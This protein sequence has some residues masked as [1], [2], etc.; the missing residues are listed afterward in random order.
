APQ[1]IGNPEGDPEG[2]CQWPGAKGARNQN[3]AN[4]TGDAR[5]QREATD[6]S[7]RA[8]QT[9]GVIR[10]LNGEKRPS[11]HLRLAAPSGGFFVLGPV[12][13]QKSPWRKLPPGG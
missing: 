1:Q 6:R 13:R 11:L 5:Q 2:V 9:H 12:Q 4:Q 3:V 10:E 8:K 7:S